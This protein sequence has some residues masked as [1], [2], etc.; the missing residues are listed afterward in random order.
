M[1]L[2]PIGCNNYLADGKLLAIVSP[3]AAP[4]RRMVSAAR[5]GGKLVD[6]TCGR[7]TQAVLVATSGHVVLSCVEPAKLAPRF[8]ALQAE[9]DKK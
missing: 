5:E 8:G 4:V 6:A 1:K 9:E 2:I 7:K 3:E